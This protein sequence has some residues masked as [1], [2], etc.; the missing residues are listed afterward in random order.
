MSKQSQ[1][2]SEYEI[3]YRSTIQP[4][5]AVRTQSRQSGAY[6]TG[7]VSGGGGTTIKHSTVGN[8]GSL[9]RLFEMHCSYS[10]PN[11]IDTHLVSILS[12]TGTLLYIRFQIL[13]ANCEHP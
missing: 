12:A 6:S 7:A 11:A 10:A 1:E 5:T 4:R 8:M 13:T 9:E 3:A 2:S